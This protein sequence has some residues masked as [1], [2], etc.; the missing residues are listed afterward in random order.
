MRV[1]AAVQER[2]NVRKVGTILR[3]KPQRVTEVRAGDLLACLSMVAD[4]SARLEFL[5]SM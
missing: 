4:T 3:G 5:L 1:S 2:K